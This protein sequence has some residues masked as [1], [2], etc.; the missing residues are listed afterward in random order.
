MYRPTSAETQVNRNQP[1]V[2]FYDVPRVISDGDEEATP[3]INSPL[4]VN[5]PEWPSTDSFPGYEEICEG[6]DD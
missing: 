5:V 4:Y 2:S 3:P 1:H 6:G